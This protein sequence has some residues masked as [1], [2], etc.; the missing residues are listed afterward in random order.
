MNYSI[1]ILV[2]LWNITDCN[3]QNIPEETWVCQCWLLKHEDWEETQFVILST[4][5]KV[6]LN[7]VNVTLMASIRSHQWKAV[8]YQNCKTDTKTVKRSITKTVK[9][10]FN[11]NFLLENHQ[12]WFLI[13]IIST[14]TNYQLKRSIGSW[15]ELF[16]TKIRAACKK[17]QLFL[18]ALANSTGPTPTVWNQ[19]QRSL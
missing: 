7:F 3:G 18:F 8:W 6:I 5:A 2:N 15:A 1:D 17:L 9:K 16:Q 14:F 4:M 10:L 13:Y 11:L 19:N 12:S